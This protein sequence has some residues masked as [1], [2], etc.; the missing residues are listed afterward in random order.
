MKT[1]L[2]ARLINGSINGTNNLQKTLYFRVKM[3]IK[4][5]SYIHN[6]FF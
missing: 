4:P 1:N 2:L 5:R 6:T 3:L